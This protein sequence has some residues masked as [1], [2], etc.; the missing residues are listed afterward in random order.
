MAGLDTLLERL[1]ADLGRAHQGARRLVLTARRVDGADRAAEIRLAQPGRDP[2]RLRALFAPKVDQIDAGFGIDALHLAAPETE[3]LTPRQLTQGHR[4][5]EAAKLADL[6]S[7]LGNRIGFD[8]LIRMLPADSHIPERAATLAPAEHAAPKPWPARAGPPRPI[9]LFPPEPLRIETGH[10]PARFHWRGR[11]LTTR[12]ADG[13]ERIAPEWWWDD[14]DWRAGPRDYWRVD[15][16][17]GP[18]LWL[19]FTP[20]N[21]AWYAHGEFA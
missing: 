15:T 12:A 17:E 19:F 13:P 21:P 4:E 18:R 1:C 3:P 10:P 7:R 9:T 14:P 2:M 8:A 11:A 5:T 20:A 16:H 6:I